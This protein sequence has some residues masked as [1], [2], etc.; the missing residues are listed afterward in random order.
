MT[1]D[2]LKVKKYK[3]RRSPQ[4][5]EGPRALKKYKTGLVVG[6]FYPPHKGHH[7]LIDSAL[8]KADQVTVAV[9]YRKEETIPWKLRAKWIKEIHPKAKVI[10]VKDIAVDASSADWAEYTKKFLGY[11]PDAVFTSEDYGTTWAQCLGCDHVLVDRDR[12]KI[13]ISGTKVRQNPLAALEFLEPCVRAYFVKRICIVGAES[14]GTTTLTQDLA[15]H[16]HTT[17]VPEYGRTYYE[18]KMFGENTA[19]WSTQEF[20]HIA[21]MQTMMEDQLARTSNKILICDTDSFATSIW[22]ER[23]VGHSARSVDE[24]SSGRH[25]DHYILTDTDIPFVQDGTRDG[26]HIRQQMHEQ[27]I[28]RLSELGKP[29]TIVSGS[30]EARLKVAIGICDRVL[31]HK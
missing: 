27:F 30:R 11:V 3:S 12:T 31:M 28:A 19:Q 24:L 25:Y 7:Y 4:V 23:Y 1:Q 13:P 9:C 10:L 21:H 6:K 18:G 22:H 14:T 26:E 5:V 2:N 15:K 20:I 8:E 17:W 16:Y 29:F